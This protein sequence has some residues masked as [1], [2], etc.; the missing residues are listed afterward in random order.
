MLFH[1]V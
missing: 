1:M